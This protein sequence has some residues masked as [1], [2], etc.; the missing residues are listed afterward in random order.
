M[1]L[2]KLLATYTMHESKRATIS[3]FALNALHANIFVIFL[4]KLP[5]S[6]LEIHG[7]FPIELGQ[8]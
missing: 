1:D 5:L 7:V 8:G 3:A 4:L 2:L 6:L